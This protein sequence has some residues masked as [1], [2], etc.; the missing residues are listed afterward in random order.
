MARKKRT[1]TIGFYHIINRGI[2]QRNVYVDDEDR[3]EFLNIIQESSEVYRFRVHTYV[4]MDDHYQLLIET[5]DLNLS[6]LMRQINGRYSMYYNKKY[7]R[8]GPLWQGRFKSWYIHDIV[9]LKT[10]LKHIES[11]PVKDGMSN[12]VGKYRWTMSSY[13]DTLPCFDYDLIKSIDL[14][15][16]FTSGELSDLDMLSKRKPDAISKIIAPKRKKTLASHFRGK[17]RELA[18]A[19]AILDGYTQQK[20]SS[21]L[22][23]SAVSVS[24]IYK[25]HREKAGLFRKLQT[26]GMFGEYGKNL[27]YEEIDKKIFIEYLFKYGDFD[28]IALG[29]FLFG[30][31]LMGRVWEEK[32]KND[33]K[34]IRL[35]LMIARI[36]LGMDIEASYFKEV[37]NARF[38]KFKMPVS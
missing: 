25:A 17:P 18:I 24:K 3:M 16:N 14:Q 9:Y 20:I 34:Y 28:D 35:N 10:L 21:Y 15:E 8:V 33:K 11:T 13:A 27:S 2:E 4:L 37:E 32:L 26:E 1:E 31:R 19:S 12:K 7:K 22:H 5:K 30:K 38:K 36:F 23:V 6:L 29:F